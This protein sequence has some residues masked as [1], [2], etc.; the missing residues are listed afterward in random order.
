MDMCVLYKRVQG[1]RSIFRIG[2]ACKSKKNVKN[3]WRAKSQYKNLR[4][5]RRIEN[6]VCLVVFLML[7]FMVLYCFT[8]LFKPIYILAFHIV[9]FSSCRNYWGGGG[10]AKRCL[11]PKYFHWGG[12]GGTAPPP[13]RRLCH[14]HL[15]LHLKIDT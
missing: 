8:M 14:C 9:N 2:R 12:G 1:R 6:C 13:D 4:R 10:E 7:N 15:E 5:A 3:F 11:P